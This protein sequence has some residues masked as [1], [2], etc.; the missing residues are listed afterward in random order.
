[1]PRELG[2]SFGEMDAARS[3]HLREI[4]DIIAR[5]DELKKAL[6]DLLV[7]TPNFLRNNAPHV[8]EARRLVRKELDEIYRPRARRR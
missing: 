1:M 6:L 3:L 4:A 8:A 2:I 5:R 7:N